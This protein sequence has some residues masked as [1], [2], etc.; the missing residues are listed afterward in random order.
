V[1]DS[2]VAVAVVREGAEQV[3]RR[4]GTAVDRIEKGAG[5]FAT[6]VDIQ[7]ERA[8]LSLLARQRPDDAVVAEESGRGGPDDS[9][10]RWLLDPLCGTLNYASGMR[11]V[12]VNAALRISDGM[13]A[14]AVADPFSGEVFWTDGR[15]AHVRADG[16]DRPVV[17]DASSHLVDLNLD[18]P[19]P[20]APRFRAAALCGDDRFLAKFKPRVVSSSLALTWVATGQR[21]AYVTDG[22]VRGSVHF[23]AGLAICAAAGCTITDLRGHPEATTAHGVIV[24][25]D[26]ETHATLVALVSAQQRA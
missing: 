21:A 16:H 11:V 13:L 19:F 14:A 7:A 3:R 25:A 4:F 26:P 2:E 20:N 6:D 1:N 17:P 12:A 18:P 23:S 15:S 10:R 24:A 9:P 22:D 8:M 5:D